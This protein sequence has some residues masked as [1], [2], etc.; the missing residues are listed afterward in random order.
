MALVA[1]SLII[2]VKWVPSLWLTG[3][4]CGFDNGGR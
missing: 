3:A 1:T 2:A 4:I